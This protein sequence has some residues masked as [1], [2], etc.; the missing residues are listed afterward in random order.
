[1]PNSRP[2]SAQPGFYTRGT[3]P[4]KTYFTQ[5]K[6]KVDPFYRLSR[7]ASCSKIIIKNGAPFAVRYPIKNHKQLPMNKFKKNPTVH[8]QMKSTY[9]ADYFLKPDMHLG[10]KKKPLIPYNHASKRSQ[11]PIDNTYNVCRNQSNFT[12]GSNSLVNKKQWVT[13]THEAFKRPKSGYVSNPGILADM[14]KRAH[15]RLEK[16]N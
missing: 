8:P 9:Q 13:T 15:Q 4:N 6:Q 11:L 5:D 2:N 7:V 1:M 3:S 14:A 12:L 16:I 10:M